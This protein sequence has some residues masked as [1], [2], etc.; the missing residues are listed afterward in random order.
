M[1]TTV[2]EGRAMGSPL[3][4][5]LPGACVSEADAAWRIVRTV[6]ALAERDLTRFDA[7]SALS[8]LNHQPRAQSMVPVPPT[9]ARALA[10]AWRAFRTTR[11]RFDPRIIGALEA[12]GER[13]GVVLPPSPE[14]LRPSDPWLDLDARRGLARLSAPIDLG[15]IGKGLALRWTAAALRHAGHGRFLL[16]AGGDIVAAGAGPLDRPWVIGI[17]DPATGRP[18]PV[19]VELT[20]AAV[21]TSSIAVRAWRD[22]EGRSRHHL[23]DPATLLP[24]A[25]V[26]AAVTVVDPDPVWA[27]VRSKVAFLAGHDIG[28]LVSGRRAWWIDRTGALHSAA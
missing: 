23:I 11:G 12:A 4:L 26:W 2:R 25:A 16:S 18:V 28:G 17:E 10:A 14:L 20:D 27:E 22:A 21:A 13:A 24:A 8:R 15:G 5:T 6:F 19:T 1:K 7:T 3:R 9:L